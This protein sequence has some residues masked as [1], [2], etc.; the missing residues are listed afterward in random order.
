VLH[1][2]ERAN[3][4]GYSLHEDEILSG[5]TDEQTVAKA[6]EY[7]GF[8]QTGTINQKIIKGDGS[9]YVRI[10]YDRIRYSITFDSN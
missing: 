9:T 7:T 1:I 5:T 2:R 8:I 3:S 6:R 10:F 4:N